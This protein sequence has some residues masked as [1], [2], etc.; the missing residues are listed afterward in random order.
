MLEGHIGGIL[1]EFI[2]AA[3]N[4]FRWS[5]EHQILGSCDTDIVLNDS[6]RVIMLRIYS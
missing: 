6:E 5:F 1:G 3:K 4:E 2:F